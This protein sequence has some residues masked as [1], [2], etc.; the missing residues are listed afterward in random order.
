MKNVLL[1]PLVGLC[2]GIYVQSL[3]VPEFFIGPLFL[4]A[5]I[6]WGYAVVKKSPRALTLHAS[7]LLLCVGF[8]LHAH[9]KA[10]RQTLRHVLCNKKLTLVA[11]VIEKE[12]QCGY[13]H[14]LRLRVYQAF[15]RSDGRFDVPPFDL[16]CYSRDNVNVRVSDVISVRD[17]VITPP[18]NTTPSDI[19]SYDDYL[20]KV[21]V[22]SSVFLYAGWQVHCLYR[23]VRSIHRYVAEWREDLYERCTQ[24]LSCKTQPYFGLIFLGY[25]QY[26]NIDRLRTR[27]NW[28]GLAHFLARAGLHIMLFIWLLGLMFRFIP[29]H[30]RLKNIC[31]MVMCIVYDLLS[32]TSLPFSRALLVFLLVKSGHLLSKTVDSLYLLSVCAIFFLLYN[33]SLLFFLDFQLTF[34]MTF[35][36]LLLG[37]K[38][39]F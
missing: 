26:K 15:N 19:S 32:W 25:K 14:L 11:T 10:E 29:L 36:V 21:G 20:L 39:N 34:A 12:R 35:I 31:M 37:R 27:C 6:I 7:L 18:R 28:W 13:G 16:F 2:F 3:S 4:C 17:I 9:Q 22:L 1:L 5:C 38:N 30:L 23:P 24:K 33:P 8:W